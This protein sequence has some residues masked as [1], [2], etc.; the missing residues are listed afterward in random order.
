MVGDETFAEDLDNG[1]T[2]RDAG[3]EIDWS[4]GL[5][6]LG[7]EFVTAFGEEGFIG[8]D[9]G[10]SCLKTSLG[11]LKRIGH[12]TDE[13]DHDMHGWIGDYFP[14]IGNRFYGQAFAYFGDVFDCGGDDLKMDVEAFAQKGISLGK[15]PDQS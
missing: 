9:E 15:V 13:F 10:L 3:F 4:V 2:A 12:A 6:C 14:P 7:D 8:G 5:V 1:N 11:N